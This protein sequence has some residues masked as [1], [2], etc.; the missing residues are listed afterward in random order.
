MVHGQLLLPGSRIGWIT[1]DFDHFDGISDLL[2]LI[3]RSFAGHSG[4]GGTATRH[5]L[6]GSLARSLIASEEQ[7]TL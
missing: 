2:L 6:A 7:D 3:L 5:C 1:H 4:N